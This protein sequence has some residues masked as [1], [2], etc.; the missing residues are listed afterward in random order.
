MGDAAHNLPEPPS[1]P[2][3]L[4]G[5]F[6]NTLARIKPNGG[7][8]G[9]LS[10][11]MMVA[12]LAIAAIA[13][14]AGGEWLGLASIAMISGTLLVLSYWTIKY[15][16]DHPITSSM[17]GTE[18]LQYG[19]A[20]H[21]GSKQTPVLPD[22]SDRKVSTSVDSPNPQSRLLEQAKPSDTNV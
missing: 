13:C 7:L 6:T 1:G 12:F 17:E 10:F 15:A 9:R 3:W 11:V 16:S 14:R 5:Y 20:V 22:S 18:L 8:V 19:V 4:N 2:S 21:Q